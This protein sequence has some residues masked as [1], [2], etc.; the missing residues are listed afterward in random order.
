LLIE[1]GGE[2]FSVVQFMCGILKSP[3]IS[4]WE[5]PELLALVRREHEFSKLPLSREIWHQVDSE[6]GMALK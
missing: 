6:K 3:V 1:Q 4:R 2:K 5:Q